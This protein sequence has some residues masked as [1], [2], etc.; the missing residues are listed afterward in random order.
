MLPMK[1]KGQLLFLFSVI[2]L[3]VAN[4]SV[5]SKKHKHSKHSKKTTTTTEPVRNEDYEYE[6]ID[7]DE[8]ESEP[9]SDKPFQISDF[10]AI[11]KGRKAVNP[12]NQKYPKT[13]HNKKIEQ[14]PNMRIEQNVGKANDK[15]SQN[16]AK[17]VMSALKNMDT[18]TKNKIQN[19]FK[20][21][22]D[23]T[24]NKKH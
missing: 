5:S 19:A 22:Q 7:I 18:D 20:K 2:W 13:K 23:D 15:K 6:I 16:Y 1:K 4:D 24:K 21:S 10:E 14:F 11:K 8:I 3:L 9:V 12:D 17:Y